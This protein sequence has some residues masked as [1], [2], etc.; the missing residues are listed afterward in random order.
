MSYKLNIENK[1]LD[2][3]YYRNVLYTTENIQLVLM[4]LHPKQEIGNEKHDGSQFI[5]VESGSG[6]AIVSGKKYYLTDGS[7]LVINPETYHNIIAGKDGMKLY[8][9]YSPPQH[10]PDVK[11]KEKI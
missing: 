3:T 11:Q 10:D 4:N 7:A 9:I 1:T 5:R 8:S 6:T 2:N